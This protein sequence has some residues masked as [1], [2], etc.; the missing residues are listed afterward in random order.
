VIARAESAL[1]RVLELAR[2]YIA[3]RRDRPVWPVTSLEAL[4]RALNG[5][6][7][8]EPASDFDVVEHLARAAEPGLVTTTGPRYFGFVTGGALPATVAADWLASAWDQ[9]A[10]LF[11]MSPAAAV[12]EEVAGAWLLELLGLPAAASVAFVTGCHMANFTA[13]AAARHELLRRAGWDV[14]ADGLQAAPRLRVIVGDEVHVSVVGALRMLGVGSRQLIRVAADDQGRMRTN[15]LAAALAE[16]DGPTIVCAQAGNVNTGA[17]DPFMPIAD[18]CAERRAWLHV[19]GAFGLWAAASDSLRHH[20]RGVERADSWATDAHKWLNVPYDSG[21]V[22]VAHPAAHHAAMSMDAAYLERSPDQA[23]EPMDWTPESSRRARGFAVYAALQSLGRRGVA[24]LVDRC[25][26]L[27]RRF[28]DRLR[29]DDRVQILNEVVLNQVLVRVVPPGGDPDVAT[30]CALRAV[31]E[32]RICW[33]GGT[34]WHG[35]RAMRISVS[36]WSTTEDDVD[37]SAESIL[38]AIRGQA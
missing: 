9:N 21:L 14:E 4:R 36:N 25:C 30:D 34:T 31:Q 10:G 7:P 8:A 3:T 17:F 16:S 22:F 5:P 20:V 18:L 26:R 2:D 11:V 15:A 6:L 13:L 35:M 28:A 1:G 24:D 27:A 23:R 38:G 32:E 37:R 33:L 19:D 12:V 29:G